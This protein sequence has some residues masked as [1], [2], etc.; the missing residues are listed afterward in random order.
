[1]KTFYT[2]AITA[3]FFGITVIFSIAYHEVSYSLLSLI[4]LIGCLFEFYKISNPLFKKD[5]QKS[6]FFKMISYSLGITYFVLF[7]FVSKNV[8]SS[9][10][11]F[12]IPVITSVYFII[13]LFL[14]SKNPFR[15]IGINLLAL[16]Y[17]VLPLSMIH[18]IGFYQNQFTGSIVLGILF[19][20]WGNDSGAYI[21]G[22]LIGKNKLLPHVSP[23]KSIEGF[24]GGGLFCFLVAYLNIHWFPKI[25]LLETMQLIKPHV[26]YLIGVVTFLFA[27]IGDLVESLLKRSLGIKDSG[28]I[29]PGHGGFL[30][31]FDAFLFVIPF[32]LAVIMIFN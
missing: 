6:N 23:N 5:G 30:D 29:L 2:R 4:I 12:L 27:T 3:L 8:I 9:K 20:I 24:I 1:M 19:V 26:W 22:S 13:E 17:I 18:F 10:V 28:S 31:R 7:Y 21:I 25:P 14:K 32:V 11:L 16:F 15:N